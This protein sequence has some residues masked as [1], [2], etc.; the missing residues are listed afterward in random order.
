LPLF[1][2]SPAIGMYSNNFSISENRSLPKE[3]TS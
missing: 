3:F 1:G 2:R